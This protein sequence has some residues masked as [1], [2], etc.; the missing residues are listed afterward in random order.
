MSC[1][2]R[3]KIQKKV[4]I[5]SFLGDEACE[6][7]IAPSSLICSHK[8]YL[9]SNYLHLGSRSQQ[10]AKKRGEEERSE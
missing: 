5:Y 9:L 2:K 6:N 10:K 8:K 4:R 7:E 3:Y 1:S